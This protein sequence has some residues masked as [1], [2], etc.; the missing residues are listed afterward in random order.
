[1]YNDNPI[2]S[3]HEHSENDQ[4]RMTNSLS[5]EFPTLF[6][7]SLANSFLIDNSCIVAG[8]TCGAGNRA[9]LVAFVILAQI[10]LKEIDGKIMLKSEGGE[11]YR[12]SATQPVVRE[13]SFVCFTVIIRRNCSFGPI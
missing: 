4:Q 8:K 7:I 12:V 10:A 13:R 11:F 3:L 1:M 6:F 9:I 2:I 5:M